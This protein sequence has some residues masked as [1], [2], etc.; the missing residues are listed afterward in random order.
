M[1]VAPSLKSVS[2]FVEPP[3]KVTTEVN[4]FCPSDHEIVFS[5]GLNTA[6][7]AK[8]EENPPSPTENTNGML[9]VPEAETSLP[10]ASLMVH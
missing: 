7:Q 1:L 4:E 9:I 10:K 3:L 8:S 5:P 2:W 6:A